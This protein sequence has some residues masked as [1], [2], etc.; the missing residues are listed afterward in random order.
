MD[1]QMLIHGADSFIGRRLIA[2][3]AARILAAIRPTVE[4]IRQFSLFHGGITEVARRHLA[5]GRP[6]PLVLLLP[7]ERNVQEN[8]GGR[9]AAGK[10]AVFR[11]LALFG[12]SDGD[13]FCDSQRHFGRVPIF[14]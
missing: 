6:A 8:A 11:A 1:P 14:P 10:G 2:G 7:D 4:K 3:R 13:A 9:D 12:P 5:A